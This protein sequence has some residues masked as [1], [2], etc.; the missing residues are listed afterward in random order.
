VLSL[1][2][3]ALLLMLGYVSGPRGAG[4]I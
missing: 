4:I 3:Y 2:Q 1:V